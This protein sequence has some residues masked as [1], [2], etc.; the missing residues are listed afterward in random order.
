[1]SAFRKMHFLMNHV[2]RKPRSGACHRAWRFAR[3]D[4]FGGLGLV[5]R[6]LAGVA[7]L[8][9]TM[10]ASAS[11]AT[12]VLPA[13]F[14]DTV[15]L[16]V[17]VE[18]TPPASA[19]IQALEEHVPAGW[20]VSDINYGGTLD[21]GRRVIRWGPF[22]DGLPRTLAYRVV[23]TIDSPPAVSFDGTFVLDRSVTEIGGLRL[24]GKRP[25]VARRSVPSS[26]EP[27]ER[28]PV[29][30]SVVPGASTL[31][32][33]LQES[34]PQ[35][36]Q[37]D[38]VP[39]EASY[40]AVNRTLKWGPF[41]DP[42]PREVAFVLR[43]TADTRTDAVFSGIVTFESIPVPVTGSDRSLL[44]IGSVDRTLPPAFR[45][46]ATA[47]ISL[48]SQPAPYVG[49]HTL[50]EDV[51]PGLIVGP[52]SHGGVW[53]ETTRRVKWGP[54]ADAVSRTLTY[55][56]SIPASPEDAYVLRGRVWFDAR[57]IPVGGPSAWTSANPALPGSL[58]A[59][60]PEFY[61]PLVPFS[62]RLDSTPGTGVR[63]H[64]VEAPVPAG[65]TFLDASEGATFDAVQRRVKWG[66]FQDA[67]PRRLE[68]RL[69][70]STDT[71]D[72]V[73][74]A[75]VGW[76][77]AVL[78]TATGNSATR[79]FPSRAERSLPARFTPANAFPVRI[80][81]RPASTARLIFVEETIPADT[82]PSGITEGGTYDAARSK[83][84]WG[85]VPGGAS[86]T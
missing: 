7:W 76:F 38:P 48:L 59:L 64:A 53:D 84:K 33:A 85:P 18:T 78:V 10:A 39:A 44:R 51:P 68:T 15:S 86:R 55:T 31:A 30:V 11:E 58:V 65:W 6:V 16:R 49:V 69:R 47:V 9:G 40:D 13:Y 82:T 24:L 60:V 56:V 17:F 2:R 28:V 25:G 54:F 61:D 8:L 27:G 80:D 35:G 32:W 74:L 73:T 26:F 12:R 75:G 50:E 45:P 20:E 71:L 34:L 37:P 62:L 81:L 43:A 1:M 36:W 70:P 67:V 63:T 72:P 79:P 23:P 41:L 57:L 83:I 52:I 5:F 42:A 14:E 29:T 77:D 66:P 3:H 22:A 46:G 19:S 21:A 4:A